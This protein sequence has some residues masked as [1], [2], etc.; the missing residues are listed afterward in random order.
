MAEEKP[1]QPFELAD[2]EL[3]VELRLD[4]LQARGVEIISSPETAPVVIDALVLVAAWDDAGLEL[5]RL[6]LAMPELQFQ[7]QGELLPAGNYPLNL[8][9]SWQLQAADLP[10]VSG[11]GRIHGDVEMLRLQHQ[12]EGDVKAELAVK[13]HD[14][15]HKLAWDAQVTITRLPEQYLP[16]EQP[17]QFG[18]QISAKGDLDQ[19]HTRA[20]FEA[21]QPE[22]ATAEQLLLKLAADIRFSDL[23][24]KLQSDWQNLQWP[25]TG[26]AQIAAQSGS[27]EATGI[28]GDYAF[29]L[30]SNLQGEGIPPGNWHVQGRGGLEKLRLEKLLAQ[31]LDGR[32]EASGDLAWSPVLTWDMEIAATDINPGLLD[33]QWPGKLSVSVST[34]GGLPDTGL[35]LQAQIRELKGLLREKPLAGSGNIRVDGD[36]LLLEDVIFSSGRAK[37]AVGGELG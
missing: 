33:A 13:A 25:L 28:P 2:I 16:L 7:G 17:A 4:L 10:S 22:A 36:N 32:L 15:L 31:V 29:S 27:L 26:A 3:P 6:D 12:I 24:F 20:S 5:S 34:A 30:Q 8:E 1:S 23:H 18:L 21:Y 37:I 14:L 19:A 11:K 35:Q 9:M